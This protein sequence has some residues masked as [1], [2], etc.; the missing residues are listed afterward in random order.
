LRSRAGF[1]LTGRAEQ[2]FITPTPIAQAPLTLAIP[3]HP[4]IVIALGNFATGTAFPLRKL[5]VT[6]DGKL[7]LSDVPSSGNMPV[8]RL[9]GP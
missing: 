7:D 8:G 1:E 3:A 5:D 4:Q 2:G 9:L 6:G